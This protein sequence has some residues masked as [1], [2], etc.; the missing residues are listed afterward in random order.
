MAKCERDEKLQ[1]AEAAQ[2]KV[3]Q[4][5][6]TFEHWGKERLKLIEELQQARNE[7][8]RLNGQTQFIC[9]CGGTKVELQQAREEIE[10]RTAAWSKENDIVVSLQS[11]LSQAKEEL[12]QRREAMNKITCIYCGVIMPK[13]ETEKLADHILSCEKS[14]LVELCATLQSQLSQWHECAR[15]INTLNR[16]M[17]ND[18]IKY[19]QLKLPEMQSERLNQALSLFTQLTQEQ[20]EKT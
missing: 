10:I 16:A 13:E 18:H 17:Q 4:T 12:A 6:A 7:I 8:A 1:Q 9:K 3:L 14:P 19:P 20:K 2:E 15:E 5:A 11:Q